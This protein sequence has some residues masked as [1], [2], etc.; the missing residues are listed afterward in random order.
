MPVRC[1][2]VSCQGH[3]RSSGS[4]PWRSVRSPVG[5][6]TSDLPYI[7]NGL[8]MRPEGVL[9]EIRRRYSRF[10]RSSPISTR[11]TRFCRNRRQIPCHSPSPASQGEP[12]RVRPWSLVRASLCLCSAHRGAHVHHVRDLVTVTPLGDRAHMCGTTQQLGFPPGCVPHSLS[13]FLGGTCLPYI[14][15]SS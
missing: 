15:A 6:E 9:L 4:E 11:M 13:Q 7:Y 1:S 12:L 8:H 14:T 2:F 5:P 10:S 3:A